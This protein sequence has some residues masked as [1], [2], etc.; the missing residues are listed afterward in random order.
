MK[1][2]VRHS[3]RIRENVNEHQL[4]RL[5]MSPKHGNGQD[6]KSWDLTADGGT[7]EAKYRDHHRNNVAL[8]ALSDTQEE[9]IVHA[10][11]QVDT[12]DNNG[13]VGR[14]AGFLPLWYFSRSTPV[15]VQG[16]TIVQLASEIRRE[17]E[18]DLGRLH[19]LM[20]WLTAKVE[21]IG[22]AA[23]G[24]VTADEALARGTASPRDLAHI[25]I[26]VSR[27]LGLPAR[28]TT[29][30]VF[31]EGRGEEHESHVWAEAHL[32][33][34]GWVGFDPC[35]D[36]CPDGRYVRMATGRDHDEAAPLAGFD[37][38]ASNRLLVSLTVEQY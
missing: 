18:A 30:F 13:V 37:V 38:G 35:Q 12:A 1:L 15:T 16:R 24:D 33:G 26:A 7:I 28:C 3:I 29:G 2:S 5:R 19:K 32:T 21:C 17:D 4:I 14:H 10:S 27:N 34:L 23:S 25:F 20:E 11:G 22:H 9:V 8:L 6:V 31:E 36:S